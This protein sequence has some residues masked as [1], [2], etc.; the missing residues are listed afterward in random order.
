MDYLWKMALFHGKLSS[1]QRVNPSR[2]HYILL[3]PIEP[4]QIG[5]KSWVTHHFPY[6]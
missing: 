1:Y 3:N 5:G 4:H 6:K 2:S